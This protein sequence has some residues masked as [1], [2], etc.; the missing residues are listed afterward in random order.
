MLRIVFSPKKCLF[1]KA[2]HIVSHLGLTCSL[3]PRL[4]LAF[5][6]SA[7]VF[8]LSIF[9]GDQVLFLMV[10]SAFSITASKLSMFISAAQEP[11]LCV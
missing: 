8:R 2:F 5:S 4:S 9:L 1:A 3:D 10:S 11:L 6:R 7:F